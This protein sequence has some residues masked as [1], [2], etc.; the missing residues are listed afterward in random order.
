MR[1]LPVSILALSLVPAQAGLFGGSAAARAPHA[2]RMHARMARARSVASLTHEGLPN[3]QAQAAVIID[4]GHD[5]ELFSRN[6]D[7]V[8]PIA[9]IS[10]LMAALVVV[11]HGLKLD[12]PQTISDEDRQLAQKGARSRLVPGM[13]LRCRDLLHATLIASDNRAVPALGR[14]VGLSPT[15]LAAEMTKKA[16]AL[17]LAHTA[18]KDP[19]GLDDNNVSTPRETVKLLQA[20]LRQ[21]TIADILRKA[22]YVVQPL[23]RRGTIEYTNTD[24]LVRSGHWEIHG[25]KTGYTDIA[26]YCL[27]VAA[28]I[29]DR[30]VG[31]AFLGAE[32]KLTRFGDFTRAADWLLR[33]KNLQAMAPGSEPA[34]SGPAGSGGR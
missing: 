1:L 11:E 9:S 20:A 29:G 15:E 27:V 7:A 13:T 2:R 4:L 12:A 18:F 31:M 14:A 24:M 19:T 10:K 25:G 6:P 16:R 22:H 23:N 30:D 34:G 32:G 5:T 3:V 8:R 33:N 21:P 17:G 28:K 26:R